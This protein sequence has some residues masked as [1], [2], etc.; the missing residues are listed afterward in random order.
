MKIWEGY[1]SEHSANLIMIGRFKE[2]KDA[3]ETLQK[4]EKLKEQVDKENQ[5]GSIVVGGATDRY[6]DEMLRLLGELNIGS[7]GPNELEQFAYDVSI[8]Q[9][10]K[11]LV[12]KTD[13]VDVAAFFKILIHEGAKVEIFSRHEY[14]ENGTAK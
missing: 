6:S 3:K 12:F 4:I 8:E 2:V 5:D 10:E 7:L 1:G 13:E 9:N 11:E 14:E